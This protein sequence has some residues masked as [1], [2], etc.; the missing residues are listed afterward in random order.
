MRV[1]LSSLLVLLSFSLP[2]CSQAP[3]A[4]P[5]T[6]K[7]ATVPVAKKD[8]PK[9]EVPDLE[10]YGMQLLEIAEADAGTIEG[11]TRAYVLMQIA[12][13]YEKSNKTKSIELLENALLS[14]R[15]M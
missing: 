5:Q 9:T 11:G 2:L 12:R 3:K 15:V 1:A 14:T 13:G 4:K 8:A 6:L 10:K 7:K